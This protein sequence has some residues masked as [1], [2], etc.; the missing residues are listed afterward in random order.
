[1]TITI[2]LPEL[3][4]AQLRTEAEL[5]GT[6]ISQFVR[7]A[8]AEKLV[9]A[10][11]KRQ[12]PYELGKHLFGKYRSGRSDVSSRRKELAREVIRAKHDRR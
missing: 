8:I 4:E 7:D 6:P 1:M 9:R 12:S 5:S 2:R 10:T 3:L 11:E